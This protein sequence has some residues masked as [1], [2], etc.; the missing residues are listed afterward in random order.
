MRRRD[1]L[2]YVQFNGRMIG[3]R[4]KYSSSSDVLLGEDAPNKP[5]KGLVSI[6]TSDKK[7]QHTNFLTKFHLPKVLHSPATAPEKSLDDP[8]V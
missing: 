7:F 4:K 3:K 8:Q 2:V 1:D 5:L 6:V